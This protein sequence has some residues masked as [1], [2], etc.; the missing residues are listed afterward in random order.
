MPLLFLLTQS[1]QRKLN[2]Q[3]KPIRKIIFYFLLREVID[4]AILRQK[5]RYSLKL[6]PVAWTHRPSGNDRTWGLNMPFVNK[7]LATGKNN[8][9]FNCV[10]IWEERANEGS[11]FS[12]ENDEWPWR[13]S[14]SHPWKAGFSSTL[15][16]MSPVW[17][18]T[19]HLLT[20]VGVLRHSQ[21]WGRWCF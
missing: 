9:S 11:A 2:S 10:P 14:T 5:V 13:L 12:D 19:K 8:S 18:Y 15:L 20:S 4:P 21:S 16:I 7:V 17:V 1:L 3:C 6:P